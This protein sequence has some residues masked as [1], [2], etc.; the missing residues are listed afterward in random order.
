MLIEARISERRRIKA[1]QVNRMYGSPWKLVMKMLIKVYGQPEN[2]WFSN[3]LHVNEKEK[4][5]SGCILTSE[6]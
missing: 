4:L 1:I 3:L 6:N 5:R 2:K